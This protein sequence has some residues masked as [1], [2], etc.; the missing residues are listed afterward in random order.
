MDRRSLMLAALAGLAGCAGPAPETVSLVPV[1]RRA[2]PPAELPPPREVALP[3]HAPY[4]IH[5]YPGDFALYWT[6]PEGRARRYLVGIG[7]PGLYDSGTF[8]MR[9]KREWPRWTPTQVMSERNPDLYAQHA[10]GM[11]GGPGNPLGARALYLHY[12]GGGDSLLRIHG[13]HDP[14]G[15]G[16]RISNGCVRMDNAQIKAL[17]EEVPIGTRVVLHPA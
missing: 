5:V 4:E 12:P 3:G 13:T 17:Y 9:D 7:L 10:D 2:P 14:R 11:P 15:L 1:D 6:L 16:R 8:R